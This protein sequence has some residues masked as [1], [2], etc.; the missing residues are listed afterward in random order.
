MGYSDAE[1]L[2]LQTF[3]MTHFAKV[4]TCVAVTLE[5]AMLFLYILADFLTII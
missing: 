1:I 2:N 3:A 5:M 4:S